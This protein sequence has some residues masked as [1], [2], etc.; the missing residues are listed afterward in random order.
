MTLNS[1]SGYEKHPERPPEPASA[2]ESLR[3]REGSMSL[4]IQGMARMWLRLERVGEQRAE[5]GECEA[6]SA[7]R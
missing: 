2:G 7:E 3:R 6:K 4:A 5:G 1:D